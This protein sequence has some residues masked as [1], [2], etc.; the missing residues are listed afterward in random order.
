MCIFHNS[1]LVFYLHIFGSTYKSNKIV[2]QLLLPCKC[3]MGNTLTQ[4]AMLLKPTRASRGFPPYHRI[5]KLASHLFHTTTYILQHD[6]GVSLP[7]LRR[8]SFMCAAACSR[9]SASAGSRAST[10][11]WLR[12]DMKPAGTYQRDWLKRLRSLGVQVRACRLY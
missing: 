6:C 10:C 12:S 9:G 4:G 3:F 7:N 11:C 5:F 8:S 1:K 2:V